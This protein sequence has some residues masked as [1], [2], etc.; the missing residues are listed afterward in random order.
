MTVADDFNPVKNDFLSIIDSVRHDNPD[1]FDDALADKC[2]SYQAIW[3]E[4]LRKT[5]VERDR[6]LPFV[7]KRCDKCRTITAPA[8]WS[9]EW[10]TV[11]GWWLTLDAQGHVMAHNYLAGVPDPDDDEKD[12]WLWLGPLPAEDVR[13]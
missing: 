8:G 9:T 11:E 7:F 4:D 6:L 13:D 1:D 3:V 5:T 2:A 10:P 12:K